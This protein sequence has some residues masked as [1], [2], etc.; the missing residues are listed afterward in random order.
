[1]R[2]CHVF[3]DGVPGLISALHAGMTVTDVRNI[4]LD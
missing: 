3:E 1:P 4:E 2:E